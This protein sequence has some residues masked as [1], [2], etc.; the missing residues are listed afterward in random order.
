M[1]KARV[2]FTRYTIM[3][4]IH[5]RIWTIPYEELGL[6]AGRHL[7]AMLPAITSEIPRFIQDSITL[8]SNLGYGQLTCMYYDILR[9]RLVPLIPDPG[10]SDQES[11]L[12]QAP[13]CALDILVMFNSIDSPDCGLLLQKSNSVSERMPLLGTSN[14]VR[15]VQILDTSSGSQVNRIDF[16]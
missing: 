2:I 4:T 3:I 6:S 16:P 1:L 11:Y 13:H 15:H 8:A 5:F 10:N 12:D 14:G 7:W 9:V